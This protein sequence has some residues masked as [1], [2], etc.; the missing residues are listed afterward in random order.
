[1]VTMKVLEAIK[2]VVT[3]DSYLRRR[4]ENI[5]EQAGKRHPSQGSADEPKTTEA[6]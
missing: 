6:G 2:R 4:D 5:E 1:M 3:A